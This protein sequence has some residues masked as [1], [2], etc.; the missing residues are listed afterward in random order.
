MLIG[1]FLA[2]FLL[3]L[4]YGS[5]YAVATFGFRKFSGETLAFLRMSYSF[6]T[7]F[8]ILVVLL[9]YNPSL[10]IKI[11]KD[12][13]I[14]K[15]FVFKAI[16][17][18]VINS[19]FP[20]SLIS[21]SQ[22]TL[23]SSFINI[24]QS[25]APFF[26][27]LFSAIYWKK[28]ITLRKLFPHFLAIFG[29]IL[30]SIPTFSSNSSSSSAPS[31]FDLLL[32]LIAIVSFGYGAVYMKVY[33]SD[34]DLI[35]NVFLQSIGSSLYTFI[36]AIFQDQHF[37]PSIFK[38]SFKD[39]II[40]IILGVLFTTGTSFLSVYVC[41]RLG[42]VTLLMANYGQIV[43]GVFEGVL[44]LHEWDGFTRQSKFISLSGILILISS[45]FLG[46]S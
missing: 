21:I 29:T 2:F 40:P 38:A 35:T 32:S 41:N 44:L 36:A 18:G 15:Y 16:F 10:M 37:F 12:L 13:S 26:S 8:F 5:S 3:C 24:L 9:Y 25:I 27:L 17:S 4:L 30:V 6:C 45:L 42:P 39:M 1:P 46:L 11:K 28:V 34:L 20:H 31:F 19:G 43:V 14:K 33:L 23:S 7:N 22:R